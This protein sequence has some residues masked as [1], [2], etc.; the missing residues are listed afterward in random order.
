MLQ[1]CRSACGTGSLIFTVDVTSGSSSGRM[2]SKEYRSTL[3]G[4]DLTKSSRWHFFM[5][6]ENGPKVLSSYSRPEWPCYQ[7]PPQELQPQSHKGLVDCIVFD[8]V[9]PFGIN[10][11][12][13]LIYLMY[14]KAVSFSK[15][16]SIT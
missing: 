14:V 9:F 12:H 6:Q 2:N 13:L 3:T 16:V 15:L 1:A 11:V 5:Q 7:S 4:S 8:C 10:K